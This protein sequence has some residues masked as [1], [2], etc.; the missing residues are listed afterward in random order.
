MDRINFSKISD[1]KWIVHAWDK[2]GTNKIVKEEYIKKSKATK[3]DTSVT[4]K[5]DAIFAVQLASLQLESIEFLI[6]FDVY[7]SGDKYSGILNYREGSRDGKHKQFRFEG[8]LSLAKAE[9]NG[10]CK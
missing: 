3:V 5:L 4:D 2:G 9:I 8:E 6:S 10:I 7:F 1:G